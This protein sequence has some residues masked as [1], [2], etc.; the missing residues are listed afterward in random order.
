MAYGIRKYQVIG[1]SWLEDRFVDV[2]AT[3]PKGSSR[4]DFREM[5]QQLLAERFDCSTHWETKELP[6]YLLTEE[7][8]GHKF[9]EARNIPAPAKDS[10]GDV[11]QPPAIGF[12]KD[13]YPD[14]NG[15][16]VD[17]AMLGHRVRARLTNATIADLATELEAQVPLPVVDRTDL[18]GS[19]DIL[20]SWI[21]NEASA[22]HISAGITEPQDGLDEDGPDLF[23]ALQE[24]L[25][26]RL[27]GS[28]APIRV[29]SIDR[30]LESPHEN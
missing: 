23:R 4:S 3:V 13:G 12:G 28:R 16:S 20:L 25:G 30:M 29:L 14:L 26:L 9:Q 5:L 8:S 27:V 24:Q 11:S 7:H 2:A 6:V 1:P 15:Q 19:Y 10:T 18:K 21:A 17:S 22:A